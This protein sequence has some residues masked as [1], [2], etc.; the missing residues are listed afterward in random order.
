M[1]VSRKG[2]IFLDFDGVIANSIE[3]ICKAFSIIDG[4]EYEQSLVNTWNFHNVIPHV[5]TYSIDKMFN[6]DLF[7]DNLKLFDG[8]KEFIDKYRDDIIICSIGSIE[9]QI[10]KLD[11]IHKNLGRVDMLPVITDMNRYPK[12]ID[13]TYINIG[14]DDVFVE[15]SLSNLNCS[16]ADYK[17]LFSDRGFEC[18]WNSGKFTD[19][20]RV[21]SWKE[22]EKEIEE[23]L[24]EYVK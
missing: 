17:I 19:G 2:K 13:K 18:E 9:N 10:K 22:I 12:S 16:K 11:W 8:A 3:A 14:R 24:N 7:W 23:I 21:N 6:S 20:V 15:D 1:T 5:D 4:V